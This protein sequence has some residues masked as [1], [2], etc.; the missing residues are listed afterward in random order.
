MKISIKNY[1]N[2]KS[3]DF[4]LK[5]GS[6]N[7]VLGVSG[8]GKSSIGG[9]LSLD[10]YSYN[11]TIGVL[12]SSEAKIDSQDVLEN[13]VAVF[14]QIYVD[15]LIINKNNEDMYDII[16]DEKNIVFDQVSKIEEKIDELKT[17]YNN[18]LSK[19]KE[20]S[21]FTKTLVGKTL[22]KGDKFKKGCFMDKLV[23]LSKD[24]SK[25]GKKISKLIAD[26]TLERIKWIIDGKT[27]EKYKVCP[28]CNRPI[29]TKARKKLSLVD[30]ID[31]NLYE[32]FTANSLVEEETGI[33]TNSIEKVSIRN[34]TKQVVSLFKANQYANEI[35]LFLTR[36]GKYPFKDFKSIKAIKEH[37]ELKEFYPDLAKLVSEI[38]LSINLLKKDI[39]RA[40]S[41]MQSIVNHN[42]KQINK[43]IINLGINYELQVE[44][45]KNKITSYK[46][47]NIEEKHIK[48]N[49]KF[50]SSLT[51][52]EET[53]RSKSLST[54][55]KSLIALIFFIFKT[56]K[57]SNKL[58]IID[59]P[60]SSCD[61]FKLQTIYEFIASKLE[62]KNVLILSYDQSSAKILLGSKKP[63]Y[64]QYMENNS[65]ISKFTDITKN[66][67]GEL[68]DYIKEEIAKSNNYC[69]KLLN[70]RLFYELN[71]KKEAYVYSYLSGILH[72]N[73]RK[74]VGLKIKSLKKSE[75]EILKTIES[76]GI[77]LEKYDENNLVK[78]DARNY[79]KFEK[80]LLSRELI[81][82]KKVIDENKISVEL[83][84]AV[85]LNTQL[86]VCLNP[87][88]Y[89]FFSSR[90]YD[91]IDKN[92]K[93][94][95]SLI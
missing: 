31:K 24:K 45:S 8:A 78:I 94:F 5:N 13:D 7:L 40:N 62:K 90:V 37:K 70:L 55:E 2:L 12:D 57:E 3:C 16:F 82:N 11:R 83:N 51:D 6:I 26:Y 71:K 87:Y 59:D 75:D 43:E 65:G 88:K 35:G 10:D 46:L 9:A 64:I 28:Y 89:N 81:K 76:L 93:D 41:Y 39:S 23:G 84:N 73:N 48:G 67:F 74:E 47:I 69:E 20:Y 58:I 53:D 72:T 42:R 91:F 79:C 63:A 32:K 44:C 34:T 25:F 77:S 86:A 33:N 92:C 56:K 50:S 52:K 68:S 61:I 14:S 21:D 17:A 36:L 18:N 80:L 22:N 95:E 66:D 15:K 85:H 38:N 54:G 30:M 1:K 4:S 27:F 60:V 29:T 49:N 19:I